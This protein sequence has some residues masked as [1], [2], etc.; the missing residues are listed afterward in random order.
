VDDN[1][2][3]KTRIASG[4][5]IRACFAAGIKV[6]ALSATPDPPPRSATTSEMPVEFGERS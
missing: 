5:E 4:R 3:G 6:S 2:V 1:S